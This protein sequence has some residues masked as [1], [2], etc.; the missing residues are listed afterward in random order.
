[1][2]LHLFMFHYFISVGTISAVTI[3]NKRCWKLKTFN[4]S[5]FNT[6]RYTYILQPL[7]EEWLNELKQNQI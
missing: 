1:M 3:Y 6:Y 7:V 2:S 5:S 4:M